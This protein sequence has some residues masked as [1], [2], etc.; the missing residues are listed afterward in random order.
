MD[1]SW[2]IR[3]WKRDGGE[4]DFDVEKL[5][6]CMWRAAE[7]CGGEFHICCDLAVAV[8]MYLRFSGRRTVTSSAIFEMALKVLATAGYHEAA[9]ILTDDRRARSARRGDISVRY[10]GGMATRWDKTWLATFAELGWN[11]SPKA[12]RIVAGQVEREL[13]ETGDN[14]FD[15]DEI[16]DMLNVYMVALGLADAVPV[17]GTAVKI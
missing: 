3:V 4:E 8:D 13:L 12:A 11:I 10:E 1:G 5:A 17:A 6:G 7:H 14:V 2:K 16:I 15:R 9:A